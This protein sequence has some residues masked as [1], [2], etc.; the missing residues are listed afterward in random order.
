MFAYEGAEVLMDVTIKMSDFVDITPYSPVHDHE[1][2]GDMVLG[3]FSWLHTLLCSVRYNFF[4]V[5][6]EA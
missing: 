5:L 6:A 3:K 2:R 1:V 4:I